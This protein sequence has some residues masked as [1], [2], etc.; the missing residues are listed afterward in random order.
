MGGAEEPMIIFDVTVEPD[1]ETNPQVAILDM[2]LAAQRLGAKVRGTVQG[3]V[4]CAGGGVDY[5]DLYQR[6]QAIKAGRI[7]PDP[8]PE[9]GEG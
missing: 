2:A 5:A 9:G 8:A 4:V 6:W 7:A 3:V 1:S